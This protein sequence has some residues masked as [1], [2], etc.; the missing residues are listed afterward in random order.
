MDMEVDAQSDDLNFEDKIEIVTTES[1]TPVAG[2]I[3]IFSLF[4]IIIFN[5]ISERGLPGLLDFVGWL[6]LRRESVSR[7]SAM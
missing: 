4:K 2:H 6:L 7:I 3:V 5:F 1:L